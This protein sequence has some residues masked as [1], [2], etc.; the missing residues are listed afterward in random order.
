MNWRRYRAQL[1]QYQIQ[2]NSSLRRTCRAQEAYQ[3]SSPAASNPRSGCP[4]E[5]Q[6]PLGRAVAAGRV[7]VVQEEVLG[8]AEGAV[9][10]DDGAADEHP[11]DDERRDGGEEEGH[12]GGDDEPQQRLAVGEGAAEERDGLVGGAED[13]EE[14]PGGEDPEEDEEREGVRQE[15]GGQ[16]EGDDG[17]VV[18][19]EVGEVAAQAGGGVGEGVRPREGRAVYH[20]GPRAP[21][22]QRAARRLG[23]PAHEEPERRRGDRRVQAAAAAAA[24]GAEPAAVGW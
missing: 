11:G 14:A 8:H 7:G 12:D 24:A 19:A 4:E 21:V 23:D 2:G 10:G 18:D 22:G 13:V 15:R 3:I 16:R 20:L 5:G 9:G 6:Q 17:G 1:K